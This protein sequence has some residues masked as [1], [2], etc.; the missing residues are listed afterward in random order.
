ML[1]WHHKKTGTTLHFSCT[2]LGWGYC[3]KWWVNHDHPACDKRL[4][5]SGKRGSAPCWCKSRTPAPETWNWILKWFSTLSYASN[6]K[7][8]SSYLAKSS[9][10]SKMVKVRKSKRWSPREA[11]DMVWVT[12]RICSAVFVQTL[13]VACILAVAKVCRTKIPDSAIQRRWQ[14]CIRV[15]PPPRQRQRRPQQQQQQ[16]HQHKQGQRQGRVSSS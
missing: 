5:K 3:S 7:P 13:S 8:N 16:Q 2:G 9:T 1:F 12:L 10:E 15:V 6:V 14:R 11:A 4:I